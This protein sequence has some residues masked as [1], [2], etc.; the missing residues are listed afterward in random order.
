MGTV[1]CAWL[2]APAAVVTS[3]VHQHGVSPGPA[4]SHVVSTAATLRPF[5]APLPPASP[6]SIAIPLH[7][8]FCCRPFTGCQSRGCSWGCSSKLEPRTTTHPLRL[9]PGPRRPPPGV[10][11]LNPMIYGLSL[12]LG[13]STMIILFCSHFHQVEGDRAAGKMSPL[14]RWGGEKCTEVGVGVGGAGWRQG[15]GGAGGR[16]WR[17]GA[18]DAGM[19]HRPFNHRYIT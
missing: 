19:L 2:S 1:G 7:P 6:P 16:G 14:V 13:L 9:T 15:C 12:L 18:P 4:P 5:P 8:H 3:P 11:S 10:T 17:G